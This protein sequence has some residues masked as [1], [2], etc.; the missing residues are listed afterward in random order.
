MAGAC[1]AAM[2][3]KPMCLRM[4][5]PF[6]HSTKA[7]SLQCRG[8][9]L[10]CS[11]NSLCSNSATMLVD[12]LTAVVGMKPQNAEGKL[13]EQGLPHGFQSRFADLRGGTHHLPLRHF[14]HRIDV[15]DPLHSVPIPLMHGVHPQV[16]RP[17]LGLRRA[18]LANSYLHGA[19][20]N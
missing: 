15:I 14:I 8:R 7:L 1:S 13:P 5:A 4:T 9:D 16:S 20:R 18:P 17:P 6:L 2:Y 3:P 11:I 10:V 12:E 19:R